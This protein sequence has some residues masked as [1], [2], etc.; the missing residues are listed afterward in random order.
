MTTRLTKPPDIFVNPLAQH[1]VPQNPWKPLQAYQPP[2]PAK[3]RTVAVCSSEGDEWMVWPISQ[4]H[5]G[6]YAD[7]VHA[8]KFSD[9]SVWDAVNGWRQFSEDRRSERQT[10]AE[11]SWK[12]SALAAEGMRLNGEL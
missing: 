3:P 9:G 12:K 5:Q 4:V 11:Q 10:P 8:I 6:D 7:R 1:P 2:P